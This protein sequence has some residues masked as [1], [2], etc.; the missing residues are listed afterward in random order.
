MEFT[1]EVGQVKL[2]TNLSVRFLNQTKENFIQ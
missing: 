1:E 2:I